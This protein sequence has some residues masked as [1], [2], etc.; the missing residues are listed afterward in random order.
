MRLLFFL[1]TE[2]IY[3]KDNMLSLKKVFNLKN[4]IA[5]FNMN[6]IREKY[7][8]RDLIRGSFHFSLV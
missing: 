7:S 4:I 5:G 1:F 3:L 2:L 8:A 6:E